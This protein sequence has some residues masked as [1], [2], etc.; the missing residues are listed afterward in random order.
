MGSTPG[1]KTMI[2]ALIVVPC[3]GEEE[4]NIYPGGITMVRMFGHVEA[5]IGQYSLML[6]NLIY[7]ATS[8]K[9]VLHQ[10][11]GAEGVKRHAGPQ[12]N[13][14]RTNLRV[15]GTVLVVVI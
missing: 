13:H 1:T 11:W 9:M 5:M 7:G 8:V 4:E 3:L 10:L 12:Y 6:V 14:R 15:F 2:V